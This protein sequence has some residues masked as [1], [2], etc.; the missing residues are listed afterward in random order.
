[1]TSIFFIL[2]SLLISRKRLG[3]KLTSNYNIVYAK[4]VVKVSEK[5]KSVEN[6]M[7]ACIETGKL[8]K[9]VAWIRKRELP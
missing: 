9:S 4:M 7:R 3:Y 1:M 8:I 2:L 5:R 6:T